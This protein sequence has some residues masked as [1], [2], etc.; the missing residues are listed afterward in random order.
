[1]EDT[2][3]SSEMLLLIGVNRSHRD[4]RISRYCEDTVVLEEGLTFFTSRVTLP[5]IAFD[6]LL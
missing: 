6:L 4:L 1:M 2:V 3:S 5:A